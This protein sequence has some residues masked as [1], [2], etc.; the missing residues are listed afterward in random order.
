MQSPTQQLFELEKQALERWNFFYRIVQT[1]LSYNT[2]RSFILPS[3]VVLSDPL[4]MS[5]HAIHHFTKILGPT[6]LLPLTI[7]STREWF[8]ELSPFRCSLPQ[9]QLMISI[10][11]NDEITSV[12]HRLNPNKAPGP[13]GL[14]SGFYKAAWSVIGPEVVSS[15][16]HF[17]NSSFMPLATNSTILSLVPKHTGASMIT[18]Y[19][20]ISCL[21]TLYKVVSRLLVKRLKP[22]LTPLIV[23][24]HGPSSSLA[25]RV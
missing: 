14:T 11:S 21:N 2:I 3:G 18:D 13:D 20:P 25:L 1:R 5:S 16:R 9:G 19:R 8:Q 17:F 15:I 10:P 22:I 7:F 23:P 24:C 12:L 4:D 6:P